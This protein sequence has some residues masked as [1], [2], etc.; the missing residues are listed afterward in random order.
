MASGKAPVEASM[1]NF[2]LTSLNKSNLSGVQ[3]P[4]IFLTNFLSSSSP[5]IA[6]PT[7]DIVDKT[8]ASAVAASKVLDEDTVD[9]VD[10]DV[11]VDGSYFSSRS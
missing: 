1:E 8:T 3:P 5:A 11:D 9:D 2:A 4:S 10:V 6:L 7:G